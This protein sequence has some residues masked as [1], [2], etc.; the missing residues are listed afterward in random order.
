MEA[1]AIVGLIASATQL[2]DLC[3]KA[4]NELRSLHSKQSRADDS[5]LAIRRQ[6]TTIRAA[7][8]SIKLW[9]STPT[10][11]E[12]SRKAQCASLDDALKGLVPSIEVLILDVEKIAKGQGDQSL[13][14]GGKLRYLWNEN[15]I[16]AHLDEAHW[17]T[18]HVHFLVTTMT[19]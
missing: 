1:V 19:L 18:H 11:M 5:L 16:K 2:I 3:L 7:V 15:D 6:Y 8:E 10:A 17:L 12:E 13:S 9:A 14:V 4:C